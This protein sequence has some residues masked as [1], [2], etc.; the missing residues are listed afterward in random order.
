MND[1]TK[2]VI[3]GDR[4]PHYDRTVKLQQLYYAYAE[5]GEG[6]DEII[7]S[8]RHNESE[9][10]SKARLR[11]SK[12]RTGSVISKSET[13]LK[14][15]FRLDK[16]KDE[17][18][19]ISNNSEQSDV[20][21]EIASKLLRFGSDGSGLLE[22]TENQAL[23]L[24]KTDPN[25]IQWTRYNPTLKEFEPEVFNSDN[26]LWV[27]KYKSEIVEAVLARADVYSY[28]SADSIISPN[29][30]SVGKI[31]HETINYYYTF[32]KN[33]AGVTLEV[34]VKVEK[35]AEIDGYYTEKFQD[36]EPEIET[37]NGNK[38]HVYTYAMGSDVMPLTQYGY[39]LDQSKGSNG[40]V[41]VSWYHEAIEILHELVD[42]GSMFDVTVYAHTFPKLFTRFEPCDATSEDG[43]EC[44]GGR[45]ELSKK[46]CT[47]C[48]GTGKKTHN[49]GLDRIEVA[50]PEF[51]KENGIIALSDYAH[52]VTPPIDI[53]HEQKTIVDAAPSKFAECV[54]GIDI[55]NRPNNETAT[56]NQNFYDTA[57][58]VLFEFSKSPSSVYLHCIDVIASSLGIPS[59]TYKA[60]LQYSKDFHLQTEQELLA[61]RQTAVNAGATPETL[62]NI[63]MRILVKQNKSNSH[64]LSTQAVMRKFLPFSSVSEDIKAAELLGLP[65]TDPN[66]VLYFNYNQITE[67]IMQYE[68]AFNISTYKKQKEIVEKYTNIY[69][70]KAK[71]SMDILNV[72]DETI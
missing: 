33:K 59:D 14:R 11:L 51:V 61:L 68:Q 9:L 48:K 64:Y 39:I 38:Y 5:G 55:A 52:Y 7:K 26:V 37:I 47:T 57:H 23:L 22:Y 16:N 58:D 62:R 20:H 40:K 3:R 2:R 31:K 54:F 32:S 29:K 36:V 60:E 21:S 45:Y 34:A 49:S 1:I 46:T 72:T 28:M 43:Q 35:Q 8:L 25:A 18:K 65:D 70:E 12:F 6:M 19:K 15:V 56:A 66:K 4:H 69:V 24:N 42:V 41:Y 71:A 10:A 44:V 50:V 27:T 13:Q 53:L 30:K 67:D 63:D 17:I